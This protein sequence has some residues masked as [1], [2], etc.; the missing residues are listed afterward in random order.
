MI[1]EF[2]TVESRR[3]AVL[4]VNASHAI[5]GFKPDAGDLAMQAAYVDGLVDVGLLLVY[6]RAC[7]LLACNAPLSPAAMP[8]LSRVAA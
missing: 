4:R 8:R 5:E 1:V 7:A 3:A 2:S 6:A